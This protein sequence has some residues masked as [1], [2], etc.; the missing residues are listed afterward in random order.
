MRV[1]P[2]AKVAFPSDYVTVSQAADALNRSEAWVRRRAQCGDIHSV[3]NP[4][5]SKG[6]LVSLSDLKARKKR[7]PWAAFTR[8]DDAYLVANWGKVSVG[9][10]AK[11]L[12]RDSAVVRYAAVK[13]LKLGAAS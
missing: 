10:I 3:P 5:R 7:K 4:Y 8:V 2:V 11:H 1:P 6:Y 13:R 12:K 9:R